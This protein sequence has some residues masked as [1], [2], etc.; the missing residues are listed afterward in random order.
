MHSLDLRNVRDLD[1]P[2]HKT[3]KCKDPFIYCAAKL[4]KETLL[5]FTNSPSVNAFKGRLKNYPL[6]AQAQL[7]F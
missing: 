4:C 6:S 3:E 7:S 1:T 2:C 5:L